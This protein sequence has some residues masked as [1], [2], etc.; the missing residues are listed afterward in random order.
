MSNLTYVAAWNFLSAGFPWISSV[1]SLN[2]KIKPAGGWSPNR[3]KRISVTTG[4]RGPNF[5]RCTYLFLFKQNLLRKEGKKTSVMRTMYAPGSWDVENHLRKE[6]WNPG[7][8][9]GWITQ[10]IS[11]TTRIKVPSHILFLISWNI[12]KFQDLEEKELTQS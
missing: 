12:G 2:N 8:M 10:V 1:A 6:T 3:K 11:R 9:P 4:K 5:M 7:V